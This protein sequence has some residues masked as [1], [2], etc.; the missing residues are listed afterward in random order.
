MKTSGDDKPLTNLRLTHLQNRVNPCNNEFGTTRCLFCICATVSVA[1]S[2]P[3][4][5]PKNLLGGM[6]V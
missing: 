1:A 3:Q 4:V 2:P 5:I 6:S